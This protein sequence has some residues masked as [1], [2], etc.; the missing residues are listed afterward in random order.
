MDLHELVSK[1]KQLA[2]DLSKTPTLI[3]FERSGISK[4]QIQKHG[5]RNLCKMAGLEPNKNSQQKAATQVIFGEPRILVLDI[6][7]APLLVRSYGLWN[8]NISTGFIVKDWYML[9]FAAKWVGEKKV[10]YIDT[11]DTHENDYEV[12]QFAWNLMDQADIIVGHNLDR[13]DVKKLNTRFL[14]HDIAPLGKKKTIDTLKIAKRYFAITSNK[15]DYIAKFLKLDGKRKSKKYSQQEMWN[16]CCNGV[17]DAFKENEKYNIQDI[18]VTENVFDKLKVW[19]ESLNFQS[20]YGKFKCICGSVDFF[21][22]GLS[23]TNQA[24]K[25]KYRCKDCGKVFTG[26]ENL[27]DKDIRKEFLK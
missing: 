4:R 14:K 15:L 24:T 11:R 3:E 23:R 26:R 8:Q 18:V 13:F 9:S 7:T 20:Y 10:H 25:Q 21:K 19:D 6:E 1:L 22:N 27:I 16:A 2:S 17:T 12:A 5:Y